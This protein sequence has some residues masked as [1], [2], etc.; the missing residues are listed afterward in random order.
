MESLYSAPNYGQDYFSHLTEAELVDILHTSNSGGN[1]NAISRYGKFSEATLKQL[2]EETRSPEMTPQTKKAVYQLM[3]NPYLTAGTVRVILDTH[4]SEL[5]SYLARSGSLSAEAYRMIWEDCLNQLQE[6]HYHVG[7]V[8][9]TLSANPHLPVDLL[10]EIAAYHENVEGV[11][12]R[13]WLM[14]GLNIRQNRGWVAHQIRCLLTT[15][16]P[17]DD[18]L[19]SL[20]YKN[21]T[22]AIR[23]GEFTDAGLQGFLVQANVSQMMLLKLWDGLPAHIREKYPDA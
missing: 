2:I 7:T 11:G 9:G 12:L 13:T 1:L 20:P 14:L 21:M 6:N 4:D 5:I 3:M 18:S 8:A 19:V 23:N 17:A 10:E 22:A 16:T 15:D